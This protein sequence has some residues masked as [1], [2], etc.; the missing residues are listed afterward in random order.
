MRRERGLFGHIF[1]ISNLRGP[2][3]LINL[4]FQTLRTGRIPTGIDKRIGSLVHP[5]SR[6][7]ETGIKKCY[8]GHKQ[9]HRRI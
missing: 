6:Y 8:K 4:V 7:H 2:I 5:E 1:E 3:T 9:G